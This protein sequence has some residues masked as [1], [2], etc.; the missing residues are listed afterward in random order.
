L[1]HREEREYEDPS[2]VN[3]QTVFVG[4]VPIGCTQKVS[5]EVF[6]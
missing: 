3:A 2:V 5:F 6:F 1:L 4:N